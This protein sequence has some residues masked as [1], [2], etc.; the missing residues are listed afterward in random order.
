MMLLVPVRLQLLAV[1]VGYASA[2]MLPGIPLGR[3][4]AL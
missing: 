1:V 2:S 3:L 4:D